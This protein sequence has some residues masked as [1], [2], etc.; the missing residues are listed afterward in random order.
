MIF[1]DGNT[2]LKEVDADNL[3]GALNRCKQEKKVY[4]SWVIQSALNSM[5]KEQIDI[6][7][8]TTEFKVNWPRLNIR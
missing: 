3:R 1:I 4:A 8:S 5:S 2:Y 6:A 7:L